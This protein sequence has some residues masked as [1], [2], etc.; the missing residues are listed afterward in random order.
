MSKDLKQTI[1]MADAKHNAGENQEEF[2]YIGGKLAADANPDV[3]ATG[4]ALVAGA[5]NIG[6]KKTANKNAHE[7]AKT[8]T[9]NLNHANADAAN[10]YNVARAKVL[11]VYPNDP[12]KYSGYGFRLTSAIAHDPSIPEKIVY[13]SIVQSD[14]PKHANVHFER[15][16]RAEKFTVE[17]T[18]GN[19]FD[20][21]TYIMITKPSVIFDSTNITIIIPDDYLNVNIWI[22]ITAHNNAGD[23]P[24]SEPFGG[25]KIQ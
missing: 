14:F 5:A 10:L 13:I 23:G 1:V 7:A 4:T 21:S 12:D 17:I 2:A 11:E 25:K 3:A 6:V 22:K 20:A 15:P 8:A 9:D 18:K 16:A 24:P 19:P